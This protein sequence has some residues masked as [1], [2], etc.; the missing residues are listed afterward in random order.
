MCLSI[1]KLQKYVYK[2]KR[3]SYKQEKKVNQVIII[4]CDETSSSDDEYL[5][6]L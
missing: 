6:P 5:N 2:P 3:Q 1:E 4:P